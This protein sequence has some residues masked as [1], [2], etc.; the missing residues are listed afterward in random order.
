[1]ARGVAVERVGRGPAVVL[2][3]GFTQTARSLGA[4]V[5]ALAGRH[6]VLS[7]DTPGHGASAE[8]RAADLAE[9]ASLLAAAT[10]PAAYVGYSMGGRI[11]LQLAVDHPERV[12][13]LAL[14]STSAGIEDPDERAERRSADLALADRLDPGPDGDPPMGIEEFLREWLAGPLFARLPPEAQGLEAR[15]TNTPAGLAASLRAAG[16]GAMAPLWDRLGELTMPVLL[17]AGADDPKYVEIARRMA[18]AVAGARLE[19][20]GCAGHAVPVEQPGE[21]ARLLTEFLA[22][23]PGG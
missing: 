19:I 20:V 11:C 1:M 3:H 9:T 14:V 6:E 7:V 23:V 8:V 17:V 21:L 15:R 5:E 12:R 10:G 2:V 13:A 22:G 18:A 4:L 16:A